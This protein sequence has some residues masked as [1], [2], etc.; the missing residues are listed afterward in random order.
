MENPFEKFTTKQFTPGGNPNARNIPSL[1]HI[2]APIKKAAGGVNDLL[3]SHTSYSAAPA[4][5]QAAQPDVNGILHAIGYNESRG[6]KGDRYAFSQPS[7]NAKYGNALGKYQVTEALLKQLGTKYLGKTVT[8]QEFLRNPQLQD[9]FLSERA[10]NL[11]S[12]GYSPQQIADYHRN[13][14]TSEPGSTNYFR[15]S[16]VK[17]FDQVYQQYISQNRP[18]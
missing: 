6:V 9:R 12:Q 17:D 15:P 10:K 11:L 16:Y 13:G 2:F 1:S 7:G 3:S 5:A 14:S 18:K 4:A 8:P